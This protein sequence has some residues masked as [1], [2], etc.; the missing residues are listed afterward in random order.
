[1]KQYFKFGI[2]T[3]RSELIDNV[4][5]VPIV[6]VRDSGRVCRFFNSYEIPVLLVD[7][8]SYFLFCLIVDGSVLSNSFV[9]INS[10]L[11]FDIC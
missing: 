11:V 4:R 3:P 10:L 8:I 5:Q 6:P 9:S 7:D 2:G 1:M